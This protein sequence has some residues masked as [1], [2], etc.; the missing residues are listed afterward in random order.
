[1]AR[2]SRARTAGTLPPGA[3]AP[4]ALCPFAQGNRRPPSYLG[5]HGQGAAREGHATLRS[6]LRGTRVVAAFLS[7]PAELV[8]F[9]AP[10][11]DERISAQAADWLARRDDQLTPDEAEAFARWRA[12]DPRH[13]AAV[14]RLEATWTL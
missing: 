1:I 10:F 3:D 4:P 9:P 6:L 8:S 7:T 13:E 11:A 12:A 2:R 14:Q 5:A